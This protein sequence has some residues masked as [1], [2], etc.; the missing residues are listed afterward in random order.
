MKNIKKKI[1]NIISFILHGERPYVSVN[2]SYLQ[3]NSRLSGKKVIITGGGRGIGLSM[4]SKFKSEGADVLIAGRNLK[5]L[6]ESAKT[7]GCQYLYLDVQDTSTFDDFLEKAEAKLG[8]INCLVNNAG[9]S[10]HEGSFFDVSAEGFDSQY[11]TNLRGSFF[12]TQKF[13]E[14]TKKSNEYKNI[15]FVSSETAMTVDERPYGL[16]KASINSL[17]Q[18]LASRFIGI[19]IRVNAIAPGI[20]MTDMIGIA[21][22]EGNL[23][24]PINPNKRLFLPEEVAEVASFLISDVSNTINGQIIY[25]NEGRT[26][27]TRW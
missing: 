18:G 14:R 9:I 7:I 12:L 27:N 3:P 5:V 4:A 22:E 10:L 8:G 16:L 21:N 6:E 13:V 26:L 1:K 23:Y 24:A 19:G 11:S 20:T 15:L 17:V 2:I 25:T